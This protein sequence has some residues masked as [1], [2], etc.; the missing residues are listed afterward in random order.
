MLFRIFFFF[1]CFL[2]SVIHRKTWFNEIWEA[3]L[4]HWLDDVVLILL[5]KGSISLGI[6]ATSMISAVENED[7]VYLHFPSLRPSSYSIGY[8]FKA[9]LPAIS[10]LFGGIDEI[11]NRDEEREPRDSQYDRD[12]NS[13]HTHQPTS[14]VGEITFTASVAGQIR[15]PT[16]TFNLTYEDGT[17]KT[18]DVKCTFHE[19]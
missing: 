13:T 12:K 9:P 2:H 1:P 14:E 19:I 8:S 10:N 16:R 3:F 7:Y 6:D 18:E 5:G 17:T 11:E 4:L 15:T